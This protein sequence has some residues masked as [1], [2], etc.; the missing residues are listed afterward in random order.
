MARVREL[1]LLAKNQLHYA[2]DERLFR[3]PIELLLAMLRLL[4]GPLRD[5][6]VA[7]VGDV[8]EHAARRNLDLFHVPSVVVRGVVPYAAGGSSGFLDYQ[9]RVRYPFAFLVTDVPNER[10]AAI[11]RALERP[12]REGV[13]SLLALEREVSRSKSTLEPAGGFAPLS[14]VSLPEQGGAMPARRELLELGDWLRGTDLFRTLSVA[15]AAVLGTFMERRT[16]EA[17]DTIIRQGEAGDD[18]YLIESGRA[19]VQ[20]VGASGRRTVVAELDRGDCFGEIALVTGGERTAD[21]VARTPMALMRLGRDAYARYLA[22]LVEVDKQ[23]VRTALERARD[24]LDAVRREGE[25]PARFRREG[26]VWAIAYAGKEIR[27]RDLR[28][29]EYLATLLR[30][31]GREF[32]A[33]DLVTGGRAPAAAAAGDE[34]LRVGYGT[35]DAGERIDARARAVYRA[36]LVEIEEELAEAERCN[37]RARLERAGKEKEALVDELAGAAR[38]RRASSD[39]ERARVTATKGIKAALDK[40]AAGHPELGAHLQATVRR[41]YF[42][43]YNP[44]PR[45]PIGWET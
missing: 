4:D 43:S 10:L 6:I 21:V 33:S 22:H 30:E 11:A 34:S 26:D 13:A 15:E 5:E 18:L 17:G 20:V 3:A 27:L 29:L 14:E 24:S 1:V 39:A 36:R 31:P 12:G 9:H 16:A 28:G 23:L 32:H 44:D 37:D 2:L 8:E 42:C 41:G 25:G 19:E 45:H 35:G 7:V 40:I 38:G